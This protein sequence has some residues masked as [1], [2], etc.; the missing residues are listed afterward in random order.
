[1]TGVEMITKEREEQIKKHGYTLKHDK[2]YD[3]EELLGAAISLIQQSETYW[4]GDW[5][6]EFLDGFLAKGRKEQLAIAAALVAAEIDR[7]S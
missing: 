6:T 7:L 2:M 1:M 4:P 5:N 3:K